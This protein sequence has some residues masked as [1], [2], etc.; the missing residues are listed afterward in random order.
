[1]R[2][3]GISL[4]E[5]LVSAVLIGVGGAY[6]WQTTNESLTDITMMKEDVEIRWL[7]INLNEWY[8]SDLTTDTNTATMS[9]Y[10]DTDANSLPI[11]S[12]FAEYVADSSTQ[13][14]YRVRVDRGGW[15]NWCCGG[16][17]MGPN[18]GFCIEDLYTKIYNNRTGTFSAV[19][20]FWWFSYCSWP[21]GNTRAF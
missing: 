15:K 16:Y 4:L 11:E 5:V 8:R 3:R 10:M 21:Y 1:M 17:T 14:K 7:G 9:P 2:Q 12:V 6:L 13:T 18:D 20:G 19:G